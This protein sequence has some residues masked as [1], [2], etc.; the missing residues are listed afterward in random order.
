MIVLNRRLLLIR[1]IGRSIHLQQARLAKRS[2]SFPSTVLC[3]TTDHMATS[4]NLRLTAMEIG[5]IFPAQM[6]DPMSIGHLWE[7]NSRKSRN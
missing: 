3:R 1:L 7:S 2:Y 4:A 6:A 5:D